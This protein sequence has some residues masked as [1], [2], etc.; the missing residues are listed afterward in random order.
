MAS[1]DL[2]PAALDRPD[3]LPLLLQPLLATRTPIEMDQLKTTRTRKEWMAE[4]RMLLAL[5]RQ[6][7]AAAL[8]MSKDM[9]LEY[10]QN[11]TEFDQSRPEYVRLESEAYH[12]GL[13][14]HD[15]KVMLK[16]PFTQCKEE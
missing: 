9:L 11:G 1:L 4:R 15:I 13:R 6:Q 2:H 7:N 16:R 5:E 14:A 12:Y 8:T 10:R 3:L